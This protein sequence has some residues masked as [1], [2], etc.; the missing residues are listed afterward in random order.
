MTFNLMP[1]HIFPTF[2]SVT[3]DFLIEQG[4]R[5]VI[6]DIDNTLEPYENL[7]P[8]KHV[9]AWLDELHAAGIGT[10]IVSNNNAERVNRFNK[11]IGMPAY[12]YSS[13][14]FP[15]KIRRAMR[16]LGV[17]PA[18]TLFI[19]DQIFTD[20]WAAHNAGAT[21][22]LVQPIKDKRG[23]ITRFKRFLERPIVKRY[24]RKKGANKSN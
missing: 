19:G 6:L 5:A 15:F 24:A 9:L 7:D 23:F 21:A 20:V 17:T 16:D 13:K 1:D 4:I 14:P 11:S 8:G 18:E 12:F 22:V 2:N 10:A 3:V